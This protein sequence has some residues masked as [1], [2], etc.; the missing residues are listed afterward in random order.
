MNYL[1]LG[2]GD[3]ANKC[4]NTR[5]AAHFLFGTAGYM[6]LIGYFYTAQVYVLKADRYIN[7]TLLIFAMIEAGY[8]AFSST[9][10]FRN[11]V[12]VGPR[13]QVVGRYGQSQAH[14]QVL[15][16]IACIVCALAISW[17]LFWADVNQKEEKVTCPETQTDDCTRTTDEGWDYWIPFSINL[18]GITS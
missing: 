4:E 14:D 1:R 18:P 3:E 7:L 6:M 9:V 15:V 13:G 12:T 8:L 10:L 17:V 16:G 5:R 2:W 11:T